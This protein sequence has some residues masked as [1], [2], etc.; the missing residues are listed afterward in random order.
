MS[1]HLQERKQRHLDICLDRTVSVESGDTRLSEIAF[2]HRALPEIH[3]DSV[4]LAS[5]FLGYMLKMPVMISCMTGGSEEGRQF[6]NRLA[7]IAG[8]TGLAIGTGSIRVM[9]R[10]TETISHF[11]LK[12]LAPEVPVLANIG[13]AQLVEYAPSDLVEAVKKIGADALYVHLNPAQE[14]FQDNGDRDFTG[15]YDGFR[16]LIDHADFPVLV[17][18]TGAGIPPLEGLRLLKAGVS[19]I[20]VAGTGGTDWIAVESARKESEKRLASD[21][22]RNWGYPT[23]ELLLAYRQIVKAGGNAGEFTDGKIIASGGLRSPRDFAVSL[24]CGAAVAAAAMPFIRAVSEGGEEAVYRYI[25]E[26]E[27]G[28]RAAIILTGSGTLENLRNTSLHISKK[29]AEDAE[30]LAEEALREGADI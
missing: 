24:A 27:T 26:L 11:E 12:K 5:P 23:G 10:H 30:E 20:D 22:F 7:R 6:N 21:S 13:A 16:R 9:L 14:L 4:S 29:L 3:A 1:D 19:Y 28:I 15:W 17:K 2:R 25:T 18:E 8:E